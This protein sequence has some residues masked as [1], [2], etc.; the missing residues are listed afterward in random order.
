[1]SPA[2]IRPRA[3]GTPLDRIDGPQKVRGTATYAFEWAVDRPTYLYPLQ[4]T[5]GAG[6]ITSIDARAA[7][8][9]PGVLAVLTHHN[10]PRLASAD[11]AEFFILQSE[12]INFRGQ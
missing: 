12:E 3:I 2:S 5:V 10:A 6:R 7:V 1:M 9:E 4:A 8:A 11:D